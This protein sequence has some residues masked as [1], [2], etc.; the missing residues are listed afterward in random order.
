MQNAATLLEGTDRKVD[1][2]QRQA[3]ATLSRIDQA[4][5]SL[6]RFLDHLSNQPSQVIFS[7]PAPDKP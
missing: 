3:G 4:V 1:A 7:A 2:L 5:D 6:N